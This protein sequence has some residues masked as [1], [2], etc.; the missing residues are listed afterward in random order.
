MDQVNSKSSKIVEQM[1]MESYKG[2]PIMYKRTYHLPKTP[3]TTSTSISGRSASFDVYLDTSY[4]YPA[5]T[6]TY[7][8]GSK[9]TS[10]SPSMTDVLNLTNYGTTSSS[11]G[12]LHP[13]KVQHGYW[14]RSLKQIEKEL[15]AAISAAFH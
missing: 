5:I 8:D 4:T 13:A 10:K 3:R 15:H 2:E 1:I 7:R 9:T 6:Y 14:E 12:Y 11:V